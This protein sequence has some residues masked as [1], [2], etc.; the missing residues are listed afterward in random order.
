MASEDFV[1]VISTL[2]ESLRWRLVSLNDC[3]APLE[4]LGAGALS[5]AADSRKGMDSA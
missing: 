4:V 5:R 2:R 3:L 1:F